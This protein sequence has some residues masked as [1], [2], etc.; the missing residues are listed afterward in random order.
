MR[1]IL[2]PSGTTDVKQG[3][4]L[5]IIMWVIICIAFIFDLYILFGC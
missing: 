5:S 3:Y 2:F 4:M 1:Y